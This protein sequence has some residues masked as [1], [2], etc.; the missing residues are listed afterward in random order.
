MKVGQELRVGYEVLIEKS[1]VQWQV[2]RWKEKVG[3]VERNTHVQEDLH[4][5]SEGVLL[6]LLSMSAFCL[7]SPSALCLLFSRDPFEAS[8]GV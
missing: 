6:I 5:C 2:L 7:L 3:R 8:W 1:L 4:L